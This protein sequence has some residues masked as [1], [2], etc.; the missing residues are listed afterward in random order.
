MSV[1]WSKAVIVEQM[2]AQRARFEQ[3]L[4]GMSE[5]D[6]IAVPVQERWTAKDIV[7]HIT[8]WERKLIGWLRAATRRQWP[9]IPATGTWGTYI[10][11]FNDRC[12]AENRDRPL[13]EV[14]AQSHRVFTELMAELEAL[15]E[16]PHH[17]LWSVWE[18]GRPPW[19]LL[20]S[21]YDH[22]REHGEPIRAWCAHS[23]SDDRCDTSPST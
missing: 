10:E 1:E 15:P 21:F 23:Q 2:G 7:A 9:D 12:Y 13:A 6:M 8:A 22:Y 14:M 4:A 5:A 3:T 11:Q 20:A 16:D 17:A 19:R 18:G